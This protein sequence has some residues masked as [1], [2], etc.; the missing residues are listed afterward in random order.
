MTPREAAHAFLEACAKKDWAE[1]Q[2]FDTTPVTDSSETTTVG[3]R[4]LV[5]GSRSK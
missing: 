2:K 5:S 1:V 3:Y 4:L